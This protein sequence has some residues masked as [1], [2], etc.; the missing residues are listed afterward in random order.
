[1]VE[2]F[3]KFDPRHGLALAAVATAALTLA[4]AAFAGTLKRDGGAMVYTAAPGEQNQVVYSRNDDGTEGIYE[5][6]ENVHV[7]VGPGCFSNG[8]C[9]IDG[10]TEIIID[11]GDG[12]D[13]LK[14]SITNVPVTVQGGEGDDVLAGGRGS[15][16]SL[17]G[18]PGNDL[19]S[20]TIFTKTY[21]QGGEGD[22][23]YDVF[24]AVGDGKDATVD[25][26]GGGSDRANVQRRQTALKLIGCGSAPDAKI[27]VQPTNLKGFLKNGLK[28]SINCSAPC[29]LSWDL[30]GADPRSED[31]IHSICGCLMGRSPLDRQ[32]P[33]F[34]K[35]TPAGGVDF[36]AT[37]KGPSTLRAV[38]RLKTFKGKIELFYLTN[39][40]G[41]RG[42]LIVKTFTIKR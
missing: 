20:V 16:Y 33:G 38:G 36:T 29:L 19:L 21:M 26:T 42:R 30:V 27:S 9:S 5:E 14:A 40:V 32:H 11:L 35:T 15:P 7:D 37:L 10:L 23:L 12:N 41:V 2:R 6:N 4:P 18:G 31:A 3:T 34:W 8:S 25:C 17:Y 39:P 28:F 13:R 1:M 24:E 22:D